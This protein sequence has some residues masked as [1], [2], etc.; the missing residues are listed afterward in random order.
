M[1]L[2]KTSQSIVITSV[3]PPTEAVERFSQMKDHTVYVVADRKTPKD[4]HCEHVRFISCAEQDALH[5]ELA[6]ILPHNH[7]CR[8]MLGYLSAIS[9]GAQVIVD[10]DDDNIPFEDWGFPDFQ[11]SYLSTPKDKG[12][13]NVYK[14]FT[15]RHIWPRGLP[16]SK[17]QDDSTF[18]HDLRPEDCHVGIWQGLA[19]ED[20]DVDAIYRLTSNAPCY[21]ERKDPIVLR[22]GTLCPFNSQNTCVRKELFP[23]LYLPTSVT[24]RYT[25]IL[26]GLVAQPIMWLHGFQLGFT[27]ATVV[28][29]RNPHDHMADFKSEIPM[30]MTCER[31]PDIVGSVISRENTI[32]EN[33][34]LAYA[35][36]RAENIVSDYEMDTLRAWLKDLG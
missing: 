31:I 2:K 33:L 10:T 3:F 19:D 23:L 16:L 4:W 25:D 35:H 17:I 22:A 12:F 36:L 32:S 13:I 27:Q 5:F 20:P 6:T 7:Y 14:H 8:K 30:Y 9:E 34:T 15:P 26:R 18:I 24:F 1:D 28:Q 21:F 29:K 11:G